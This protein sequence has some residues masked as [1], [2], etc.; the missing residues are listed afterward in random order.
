MLSKNKLLPEP[1]QSKQNPFLD[2]YVV[3]FLD[4]PD[5]FQENDF[6]KALVK[7][8]CS[9]ILELEKDFTFIG[10]EYLSD[11]L[12]EHIA[13]M[14]QLEHG[15]KLDGENYI[16]LLNDEDADTLTS[17]WDEYSDIKALYISKDVLLTSEQNT[18]FKDI[19]KHIIPD[20]YFN[21]ELR[22]VGETW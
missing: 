16:M 7:G 22:E 9:F 20:Y 21:F 3:E 11:L 18:L 15:I 6:R 12:L 10:E 13:E 14:I 8:M 19:E 17:H 4:L 5:T 2:Q 1:L